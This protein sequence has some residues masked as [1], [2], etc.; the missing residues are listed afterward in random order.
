MEKQKITASNLKPYLGKVVSVYC[1]VGVVFSIQAKLG[2]GVLTDYSLRLSNG[3]A[4]GF[5]Y[6]EFTVAKD[7]FV[8]ITIA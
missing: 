7:G 8:A 6:G 2:L 1:Q 3:D 4:I 5:R